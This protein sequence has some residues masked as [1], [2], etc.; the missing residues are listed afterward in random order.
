MAPL[1]TLQEILDFPLLNP[2][3]TVD[4]EILLLEVG[5]KIN[6]FGSRPFECTWT[7]AALQDL[8]FYPH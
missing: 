1:L 8:T 4:E 5:S 6:P 2:A 7:L 3:W